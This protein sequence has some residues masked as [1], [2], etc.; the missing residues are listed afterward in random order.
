M[1]AVAVLYTIKEVAG[2]LTGEA[3]VV[4][5]SATR[6]NNTPFELEVTSNSAEADG[7]LVPIPIWALRLIN[8]PI[9]RQLIKESMLYFMGL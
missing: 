7:L 2:E 3:E 6:G 4:A 8:D 5:V 9:V 1:P